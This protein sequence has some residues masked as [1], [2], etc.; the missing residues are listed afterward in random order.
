LTFSK[1][2][3]SSLNISTNA[4]RGNKAILN[5]LFGDVWER[6]GLSK[7]DRSLVTITALIV[8]NRTEHLKILLES[9]Q[10]P[11]GGFQ[12]QSQNG[13]VEDE[14]HY[15]SGVLCGLA[16]CRECHSVGKGTLRKTGSTQLK[17]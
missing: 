16:E 1:S 12:A 10:L 3:A 14:S 7:R 6:P 15:T 9:P 8:L 11:L 13:Q 5:V 2:N 17:I 4:N